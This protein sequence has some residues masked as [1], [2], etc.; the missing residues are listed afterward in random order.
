[1]RPA[2]KI[3]PRSRSSRA[4]VL[5][6]GTLFGG[7][8]C[9][10]SVPAEKPGTAT[11]D[12]G[13]PAV[14]PCVETP[15]DPKCVDDTSALFVSK[16]GTS[17]GEGTRANPV[18]TVGIAL[19]KID[20]KRRRIYI[21]EGTYEEDVAFNSAQNGVS[22]IGGVDCSWNAKAGAK[23]VLGGSANPMKAVGVS[24]LA[25]VDI[26]VEAKDAT[27][28]GSSIALFVSG[29]D[30][31]LKGVR[32][33]AGN[34]AKG[35]DGVL[36]PFTTEFPTQDALKGNDAVGNDG[37]VE[38]KVTCPG[39]AVTV[40]GR[41]GNLGSQGESGT[42]GPANVG[43]IAPCNAG[44][45]GTDGVPGPL[46]DPA[47][48]AGT[49]GELKLDGW[50]PQPGSAG[51]IGSPGDGRQLFLPGGGGYGSSGAGGS[52]GAGG[53]GGAGG[54]GGN[55]GGASIAL[56]AF[57]ANVTL[58]KSEV[59]AKTAGNG[60]NGADGQAG[61]DVFGIHGNGSAAAC[62]GGNGAVGGKGGAG[63]GGAGGSSI[64]IVYKNGKVDADDATKGTIQVG[65]P[66]T[67]GKDGTGADTNVGKTG[68]NDP[69]LAL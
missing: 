4:L 14:S 50:Y 49:P 45:G 60:G 53:C 16:T 67:G 24:G 1:M 29:G 31:T 10:D 32:L 33:V 42:P 37:G 38:K 27:N 63:G 34:G 12:A 6:V 47:K 18:N 44:G 7:A 64:G 19:Q 13:S 22:L 17:G 26:A 8:A 69:I 54:A 51:A 68:A 59:R 23:P 35:E 52:G 66:G 11:D 41:G 3:E 57:S 55:G 40:G 20:A 36:K 30:V 61:Q 28:G 5:V 46:K 21:C 2:D 39:G 62:D 25:L 48:S 56:A 65:T 58:M 43:K 9:G 15:T